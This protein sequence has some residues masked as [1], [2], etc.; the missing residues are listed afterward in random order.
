MPT[1]IENVF[2]KRDLQ[3]QEFEQ[4]TADTMDQG[5]SNNVTTQNLGKQLQDV[6]TQIDDLKEP[7]TTTQVG[8]EDFCKT[9]VVGGLIGLSTLRE[10]TRYL[11][12]VV[13]TALSETCFN[14]HEEWFVSTP[15]VN[16]DTWTFENVLKTH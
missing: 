12:T 1:Q 15:F 13:A 3:I 14:L 9:M 10:A 7:G 11:N 6:Q 16:L 2:H 5:F 4:Y 8:S